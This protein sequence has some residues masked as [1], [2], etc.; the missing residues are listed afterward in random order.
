MFFP[1]DLRGRPGTSARSYPHETTTS[2]PVVPRD[3]LVTWYA[4]GRRPPALHAPYR[5]RVALTSAHDVRDALAELADPAR[6][7]TLQRFFDTG[8]GGDGDG[9]V[10]LGMPVP[11][12]RRVARQARGLPLEALAELLAS[13]VHEHRFVALVVLVDRFDRATPVEQAAL[14]RWYFEHR[15]GVNHWDLVDLSAPRI[16]GPRLVAGKRDVVAGLAASERVWDRRIAV[17]ATGALIRE[18]ELEP[19]FALAERLLE[20]PHHLVHKAVGW[21]LREAGKRD[22]AALVRWLRAHAAVMPRVT[23][24]YAI[25]RLAPALRQEL[26]ASGRTQQLAR[27]SVRR[28]TTRPQAA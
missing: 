25:E 11:V 6:A 14:A 20:D 8:P 1:V 27:R 22:E 23:L 19:T 17:L 10:F 7:E 3:V 2:K 5:C 16:L 13:R 4:V 28:K 9:D 24:R 26:L 15:E 12:Q 21:M 18:G